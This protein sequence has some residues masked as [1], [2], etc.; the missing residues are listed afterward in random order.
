MGHSVRAD[1]RQ[2]IVNYTA[3]SFEELKGLI[4]RKLANFKKGIIPIEERQ[5]LAEQWT[6]DVDVNSLDDTIVSIETES[7]AKLYEKYNVPALRNL[8]VDRPPG[9][10]RWMYCQLNSASTQESRDEKS[11]QILQ[12]ADRYR[13][14]G[15]ALAEHCTNF[16]KLPSSQGLNT[17][18][19]KKRHIKATS[20]HNKH[21][22]DAI[23]LPGGTGLVAMFELIKCIKTSCVDF[24]GLGRWTSWQLSIDP[25]HK[26]RVV[27]A[28]GIGKTKPEGLT[29]NYQQHLCYIQNHDMDTNPR[30]MFEEDLQATLRVWRSQGERLLIFMD[31]NEHIQN[32]AFM[33][34][35]IND[36]CLDLR[37][38]THHHWEGAPSNSFVD[39]KDP[40]DC[41]L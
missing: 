23:Y 31:A 40:I 37:E 30:Q 14:Q 9:V 20:A 19:N 21:E 35:L 17:W 11:N 29:T 38:E 15:V 32:G 24:R 36:P 41:V 25:K 7:L 28:Y 8:A 33:K 12:L 22:T 1:L 16:T 39:G 2:G 4:E 10:Y 26:T 34:K 13:V 5:R 6:N 3:L 18:F 27:V